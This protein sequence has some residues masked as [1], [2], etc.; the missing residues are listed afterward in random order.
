MDLR[1]EIDSLCKLLAAFKYN[2]MCEYL[3]SG[4]KEAKNNGDLEKSDRLSLSKVKLELIIKKLRLVEI[5][6]E[7]D[8]FA[9]KDEAWNVHSDNINRKY[10]IVYEYMTWFKKNVS[11][12]PYVFMDKS[13]VDNLGGRELLLYMS[14]SSTFP[15]NFIWTEFFN[16][17]IDEGFIKNLKDFND[18]FTKS[19]IYP[20]N[21]QTNGVAGD[22]SNNFFYSKGYVKYGK[23]VDYLSKVEQFDEIKKELS[24]VIEMLEDTPR[25]AHSNWELFNLLGANEDIKENC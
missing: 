18:N 9:A 24:N 10:K 16:I 11:N 4:A 21:C 23:Y 22:N 19:S 1:L 15:F 13:D 5:K 6:L 2:E 20:L 3:W 7:H 17:E 25:R 12:F 14:Y 8:E